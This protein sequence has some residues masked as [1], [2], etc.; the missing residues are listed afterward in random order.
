MPCIE[1]VIDSHDKIGVVDES[2]RVLDE[3]T[4]LY[5]VGVED[6]LKLLLAGCLL[7]LR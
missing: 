7:L 6:A 5:L 2:H 3:L 4:V 1:T